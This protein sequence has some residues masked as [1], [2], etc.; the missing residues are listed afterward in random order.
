MTTGARRSHSSGAVL[1]LGL[2]GLLVAAVAVAALVLA[3]AP[4]G[5][6]AAGGAASA[7]ASA[8][9]SGSTAGGPGT[10][11]YRRAPEVRRVERADDAPLWWSLA[12]VSALVL[13]AGRT[14][15]VATRREPLR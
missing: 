2:A 13:V 12:G 14:L 8:S 7:S 9:A 10:T 6:G 5:T 4:R 3:P 11:S 1:L 15:R